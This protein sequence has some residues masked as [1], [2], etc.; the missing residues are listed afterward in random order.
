VPCTDAAA[1]PLGELPPTPL[2]GLG[3]CLQATGSPGEL[4]HDTGESVEVLRAGAAG[5]A[6]ADGVPAGGSHSACAVAA[7]HPG[8]VALVGATDDDAQGH[9]GIVVASRPAGGAFGAP[10]AVARA[11]GSVDSIV[12]TLSE[13]GDALVAWEERRGSRTLVRAVLRPSGGAFGTPAVVASSRAGLIWLTAGM[14]AGGDAILAWTTLKR[15]YQLPSHAVAHASIAPAGRPFGAAEAIDEAPDGRAAALGVAAD[16]RAL[17]ALPAPGGL[18]VAERPPG[19]EFGAPGTVSRTR[20]TDAAVAIGADGRAA[21]LWTGVS[22]GRAT[23]VTRS[24]PGAFGP[25][26]RLG[27]AERQGSIGLAAAGP[28]LGLAQLRFATVALTPD[29]VLAAWIVPR[30]VAGVKTL[31]VRTAFVPAAGGA[32]ESSSL[33]DGLRY[34]LTLTTYPLGDGGAGVAWLEPGSHGP[35]LLHA[36]VPGGARPADRPAPVVHVGRPLRTLLRYDQPLSLPVTCDAACD[37][38]AQVRGTDGVLSLTRAGRGILRLGP[39]APPL[40]RPS[41][42]VVRLRL[43]S[44]APGA[45][46]PQARTLSLHLRLRPLPPQPRAF[47][48]RAVRRPGDR[49]RVTWRTDLASAGTDFLVAGVAA[50]GGRALTFNAAG[51]KRHRRRFAV[52]LSHVRGVRFVRLTTY[53]PGRIP[54]RPLIVR[55]R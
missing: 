47:D 32:V 53:A 45:A 55:V 12:A 1:A 6:A 23:L 16:G 25:A 54:G 15:T 18:R 3:T 21:I 2:T 31:G 8:G 5:F 37:V 42:G 34:A 35:T 26:V 48:L 50:R 17:L 36:A 4:L 40:A 7:G 20:A 44:G 19:G 10:A 14:S 9:T 13:R 22:S 39:G 52:A 43:L 24:G 28:G 33:G 49:I 27:R 11:D 29:G 41:G 46:H 30:R 51:G 38:H